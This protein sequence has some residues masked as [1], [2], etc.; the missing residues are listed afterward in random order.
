MLS[1]MFLF[2]LGSCSTTKML[3]EDQSRLASNTVTVVNKKEHPEYQDSKID[4][5]IRQKAN[6]Y[7]IKT[8]KGGWNPFLYVYN[9]TNGKGGGWDKFV[10]RLGQAPVVFDPELVGASQENIATHLKYIGYYDSKV[11]A[12]VTTKKKKTVVD[13]KVSLGKQYPIKSIEYLIDDPALAQEIYKDTLNSLIK[14]GLPLSEDLLD[15]ETERSAAHLRNCGYYEFSKNY[16]FFAADTVSVKDS[17]LLRISVRDYTRNETPDDA[18]RHRK[19]YFGDVFVY[20]VSDNI[21]YRVSVAKKIPQILDTL[22]YENITIL[23]D[24]KRKVRPSILYKMNRIEPGELYSEDIVNNTYQR[25]SNL[26]IY[27]SV[28]VELTKTDTNVVDCAIRLIPSKAHGYKINLEASS[29]STGLIGISPSLSYYNRNIFKGGE[30]LSLSVSGNFQ[31]SVRDETRATE[32]GASAGLSFPTFVLLPDRMFKNIIPRTDLDITYNYQR[33]PEYTRNMIGAGFGWSW[34]SQSNKY[35]F[36]VVPVQFNIVNLP[37]YSDSFMESLTNPFV[38]EAYKNHFEFGLGFDVQYSSDP[39]INPAGSFFK[40]DFQFDLAGNLL[41][42]FNKFMP[43]DSSGFHTIWSSPYSQF[44]R[45]ELSLAYTWKF[46]KNNK[47]ALA[48]RALGGAGYAYG[49]ST[50]MPFERLFWAGGANSLR[51]W[52]ARSVGP[53]SSEM[54]HTFSIP[55]QTGDMRLEANIEYRFPLFSIFR[56]AIFADWGN[57]WNIDRTARDHQ[58]MEGSTEDQTAEQLS[59]FSIRNIFRTSALNWGAGLR[60]DLNFVVVR[61]DFGIKLYDPSTQQWQNIDRW[62]RRGGYAFQFG[63]GYPF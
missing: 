45:A 6:T 60:L 23:Y 21:R 29:N 40:A 19:F 18:R 34:S 26:R 27:S 42:A 41:S 51:G 53:G 50:K 56:G 37:V 54:D 2:S 22:K 9:W 55:N 47:Q 24:K 48:V 36:K 35:Y 3:T 15:N 44:V 25:F 52:T 32:F 49:N 20:P 61:L 62:F 46:G 4:N 58:S 57:V 1:V 33:R 5:Y 30:W 8:K 12:E 13:Y 11:D 38:R 63:I 39:S 59:Y 17:A 28:N 7:F 31:F 43:V 14:R 16:Y 10:T